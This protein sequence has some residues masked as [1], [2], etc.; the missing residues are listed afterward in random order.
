MPPKNGGFYNERLHSIP[1]VRRHSAPPWRGSQR[2]DDGD[3][4]RGSENVSA[5]RELEQPFAFSQGVVHKRS[6]TLVEI[7][8]DQGVVGWGEAFNQGLEPPQISAATIEHAL[9]PLVMVAN[10]LD[11]EVLWQRMYQATRNYGRKG[12]VMAA[13]SAIDIALWDIAGKATAYP[14]TSFSAGR[15]ERECKPM[16]RDFIA[17]MGTGEAER[18]ADEATAHADAGFSAMKVKLGFGVADDLEVMQAMARAVERRGD[19]ADGRYQSSRTAWL[20]HAT[21][22]GAGAISSS[23]G[24]KSRCVPEDYAGYAELRSAPE[25]SDCRRRE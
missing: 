17:C 18:L 12:S 13:I 20:T 2:K 4:N 24:T 8:T 5:A 6:A 16:P 19:R 23:C 3:E 1:C 9:K 14:S 15:F 10:P 11:T 22:T 25:H 7:T 21:G